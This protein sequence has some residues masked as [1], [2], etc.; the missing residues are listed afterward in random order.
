MSGAL[1][2][3]FALVTGATG[4]IGRAIG[5][6]L[7]AAGARVLLQGRTPARCARLAEETGLEV[8]AADLTRET[9]VAALQARIAREGRLEVLVLGAGIYERSEDPEAL[10]RQLEANVIGPY[11]LLRGLLP[12]LV[13]ARGEVVFLNSTQGLNAS[14]E[15]GQYAATHHAMRAIADSLRGEV[16]A[17]GVRVLSLHLGRTASERQQAIFAM[18]GRDYP[19]EHLMQPKDVAHAVL[20]MLTL[21]RTAEAT[22]LRLRPMRK[23]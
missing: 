3:W 21:P 18:E 10:R 8:L 7:H 17:K 22:E 19:R 16:N 4:H 11:A 2:G 14:P 12:L 15:V 6:A 9:D 5:L 13:A 1:E 23:V 20:A